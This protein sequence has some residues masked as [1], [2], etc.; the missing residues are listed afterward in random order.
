MKSIKVG[1]ADTEVEI[2]ELKHRKNQEWR[3]LLEAKLQVI[4]GE[5]DQAWSADDSDEND[6]SVRKA[7]AVADLAMKYLTS[8]F[9]IVVELLI[10]YDSNLERLMKDAYDS[11]LADAFQGV[12]TLAYPFGGMMK[13]LQDLRDGRAPQTTTQ[14]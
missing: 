11:E 4:I 10:A 2:K 13:S 9:G 8:S 1:L 7:L 5:I 12:L 3:N 6:L 14:N